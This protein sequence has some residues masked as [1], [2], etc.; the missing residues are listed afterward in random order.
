MG[1]HPHPT[2]RG[3]EGKE[4]KSNE[5]KVIQCKVINILSVILTVVA[6]YLQENDYI[7]RFGIA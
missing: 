1:G 2:P 5:N 3:G 4:T 6:K 7:L